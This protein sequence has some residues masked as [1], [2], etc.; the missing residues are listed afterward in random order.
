MS[1]SFS[2]FVGIDISKDKF[3]DYA[4]QNPTSIL[5]EYAFDISKQQF[6]SYLYCLESF[7]FINGI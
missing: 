7:C 3:N 1:E 2:I 5:F 4:I 6:S